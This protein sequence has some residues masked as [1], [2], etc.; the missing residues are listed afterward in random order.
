MIGLMRLD[1]TRKYEKPG[2]LGAMVPS[3]CCYSRVPEDRGLKGGG[4]SKPEYAEPYR[5]YWE[6]VK[7]Q[8]ECSLREQSGWAIQVCRS[9]D[10]MVVTY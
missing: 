1:F 6:E 3:K 9:N 8:L 10:E 5:S 2:L 7:H 4:D